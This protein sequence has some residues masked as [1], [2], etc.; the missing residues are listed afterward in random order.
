MNR[1]FV[2]ADFLYDRLA[3]Q[4]KP[5]VYTD[6]FP[7]VGVQ[8]HNTDRIEKVYTATFAAPGVI[9]EILGRDEK[10]V[11]LFCHHPV[12]QM[13]SLEAGYGTIPAELVE[14]MAAQ[15]ITLFSYHIPLDVAGPYSPGNTLAQAMHANPYESWYPQNGA[16]L[17]ALC[18]TGFTTV[19]E[20]QDCFETTL[21]H[22]VKCYRYGSE[23]LNNGKFAIM[24]GIARS[25]D[26]YR[27]LKEKGINVMVTGVT[28]QSV[29]WVEKIHAAAKEHGITLLG[30]T[31][32]STEKFALMA[33]CNY[34]RNLGIE[35]EFLAEKPNMDEM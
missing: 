11:M 2:S 22:G 23:K 31:H 27:F 19:T 35:A 8:F 15:E 28:A 13:P 4:F 14:K 32:Y 21:G 20:L 3:E 6:V 26:A 16:Q 1:S 5:E 10:N 9:E 25:T 17:G 18:Q 33:L 7:K 24:A 29:E 34:F 12:P 30:G